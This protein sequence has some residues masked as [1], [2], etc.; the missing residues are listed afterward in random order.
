[1]RRFFEFVADHPYVMIGIILII[2]VGFA[3][4]VP[5]L[6]TDTNFKNYMDKN[7]PTVKAMDRAED[8]YGSQDLFMIAVE[9][10][11]GIFN[12]ETL[13]KM[14]QMQAD[15]ENGFLWRRRELSR[16]RWEMAV[17]DRSVHPA[18]A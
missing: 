6:T 11:S 1:M 13:T 5:R 15:F 18:G 2:T 4:F 17:S 8:R 3:S 14:S 10:D 12:R 7:D 16:K 9:N